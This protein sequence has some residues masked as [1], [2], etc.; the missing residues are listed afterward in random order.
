MQTNLLHT[1]DT[2]MTDYTLSHDVMTDSSE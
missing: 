2:Q 1:I